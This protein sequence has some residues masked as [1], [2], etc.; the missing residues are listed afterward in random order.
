VITAL[1]VL[2]PQATTYPTFG[3]VPAGVVNVEL[4][5]VAVS[6]KLLVEATSKSYVVVGDR[7]VIVT[8]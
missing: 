7:P 4:A 8:E 2:I 3:G 5:D 6:E 1:E